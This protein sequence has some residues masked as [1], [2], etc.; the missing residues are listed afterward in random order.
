MRITTAI[1]AA[2]VAFGLAAGGAAAQG[3]AWPTRSVRIVVP[4]PP[5]GLSDAYSRLLAAGMAEA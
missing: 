2:C 4:N 5:G 1:L 3:T